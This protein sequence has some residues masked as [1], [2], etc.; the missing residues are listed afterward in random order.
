METRKEIGKWLMDIAKYITT[1]VLLAAV[2]GNI[3]ELWAMCLFSTITIAITMFAGV[4]L[5]RDRK[6]DE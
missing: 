3:K 5:I 4:M 2:F 6:K 1:A